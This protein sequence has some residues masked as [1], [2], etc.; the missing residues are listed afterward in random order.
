M[1]GPSGNDGWGRKMI[2]V[3]V[4]A[5]QTAKPDSSS[6]PQVC[7]ETPVFFGVPNEATGLDASQCQPRCA[8]CGDGPWTQ[9]SYTA[10]DFAAWRA[11]T[12][13]NPLAPLTSDPY[14]EQL[15]AE[16][17]ADAVCGARFS[18]NGSYRLV[19]YPS[20][21]AALADGAQVTHYGVCGRC[22]SLADLAVYAEIPDLT[23]PVRSCGLQNL[24][25][26]IEDL[27][28][29][30]AALGF[31]DACASIWAYNT[32]HTQDACL[33][34]CIAAL[35]DPYNNSDGSLNACLQCDEDESGTVF[36]AIAGR[37]RRNTGLASSICR[38]CSEVKPLVHGYG[39]P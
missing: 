1:G 19:D 31:T 38:P 30:I 39:G 24:S 8:S 13:E 23:E 25:G 14:L 17:S 36:K 15:P 21:S 32:M 6:E 26:P 5:C 3:F 2:L 18:S 16:P 20:T 22:S 33:S 7:T 27:T 29:C 37:T 28:A 35:D 4:I 11:W 12:L 9:P 10:A 34:V